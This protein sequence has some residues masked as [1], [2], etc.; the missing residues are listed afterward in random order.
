VHD[1]WLADWQNQL[2][3]E[4]GRSMTAIYPRRYCRQFGGSRYL[5]AAQAAVFSSLYGRY[6]ICSV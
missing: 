5:E 3:I 6:A 2:D 4:P 1:I